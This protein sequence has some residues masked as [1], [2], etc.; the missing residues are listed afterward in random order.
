MVTRRPAP[1]LRGTLTW[2]YVRGEF[3]MTVV[4]FFGGAEVGGDGPSYHCARVG[5]ATNG[6]RPTPSA[7]R[8][9]SRRFILCSCEAA[10]LNSLFGTYVRSRMRAPVLPGGRTAHQQRVGPLSPC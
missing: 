8:L 3:L 10:A 6:L 1:N 2:L 4:N 5:L 9:K 7:M